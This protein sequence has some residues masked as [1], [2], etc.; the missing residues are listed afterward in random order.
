MLC[1]RNEQGR[2]RM[3]GLTRR[4]RIAAAVL[5]IIASVPGAIATFAIIP[6]VARSFVAD[7]PPPPGPLAEPDVEQAPAQGAPPQPKG[8]VG[9]GRCGTYHVFRD[10]RCRDV[11]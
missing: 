10:G 11:R 7:A 1:A 5:T 2:W 6:I 8:K 3:R 9:L 4:L